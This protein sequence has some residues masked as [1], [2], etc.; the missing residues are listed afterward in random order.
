MD[1]ILRKL[2]SARYISTLD[3]KWAYHQIE[4][5]EESRPIT[6]FS[7][8]G[9]GLL[10]FKRMPFGLSYAP[11]TFQRLID[12]VIGP[13][14]EP[15]AYSYLDDIIIA[16]ESF[17]K[18]T[19]VLEL[20]LSRIHEAGLTISREKSKFCQQ[21]VQYLGVL[22]NRDGFRPNPATIEAIVNY[23]APKNVR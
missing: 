11:A 1:S 6:A 8:P 23:P 7:V 10:Q 3:L 4:V 13:E 2:Q 19:K 21:E 12:K 16:T 9:R 17:E 5:K 18:H 20:V 15:Y 14:L 22:V